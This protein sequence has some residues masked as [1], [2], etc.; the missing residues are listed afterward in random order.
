M[1]QGLLMCDHAGKLLV[2]NRRF[3]QM[4]GL[5][6]DSLDEDMTYSEVTDRVAA[7]GNVSAADMQEVR[8]KRAELLDRGTRTVLTWSLSDGRVLNGRTSR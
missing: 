5:P 7:V 1:V 4:F 8:Q 3:I 6:D 2:V